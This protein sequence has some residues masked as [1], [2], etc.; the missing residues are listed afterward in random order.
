MN[1]HTCYVCVKPIKENPVYV[2]KDTFRH[3]GCAP[4]S[5]QWLK[6]KQAKVSELLDFFKDA[7]IVLDKV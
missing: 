2:G 5:V 6:S 4:G 1:E 7:K 3:E